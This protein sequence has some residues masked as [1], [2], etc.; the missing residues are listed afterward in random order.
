MLGG[1]ASRC[2]HPARP[3]PPTTVHAATCLRDA[4]ACCC[5]PEDPAGVVP[6]GVISW[7]DSERFEETDECILEPLTRI[8]FAYAVNE[9]GGV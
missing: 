3:G 8:C 9:R 7:N 6:G 2:C 4:V 1:S 5:P